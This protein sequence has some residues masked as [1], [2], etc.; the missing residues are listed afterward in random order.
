MLPFQMADVI[1][2]F[3]IGSVVLVLSILMLREDKPH[4]RGK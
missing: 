1:F 4:C 2:T 3:I